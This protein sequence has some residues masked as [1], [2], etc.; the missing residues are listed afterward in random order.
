MCDYNWATEDPEAPCEYPRYSRTTALLLQIFLGVF[1][2]GISVL[3]WHGAIGL[4]W[5]FMV[6]CCCTGL[7]TS[8]Y[9][10]EGDEHVGKSI[11]SMAL[12]MLAFFGV[13]G[14]YI[15]SI[16]FI[17]GGECMD[18]NGFACGS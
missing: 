9:A 7:M 8:V 17:A 11:C 14:T 12:T 3:G 16:V 13:A 4:Y 6:L 5:G 15:T 2:V 18:M 10:D 1:G